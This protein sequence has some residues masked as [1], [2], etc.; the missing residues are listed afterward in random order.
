MAPLPLRLISS[1]T[2][3]VV[4]PVKVAESKALTPPELEFKERTVPFDSVSVSKAD[5]ESVNPKPEMNDSASTRSQA[6]E[7]AKEMSE[8]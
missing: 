1:T 3:M 5:P 6:Q 7:T 8:S 4:T 2:L